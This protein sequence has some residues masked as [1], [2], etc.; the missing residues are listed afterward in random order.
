MFSLETLQSEHRDTR[1]GI[2]CENNEKRKS[3]KKRFQG[4]Q[5]PNCCQLVTT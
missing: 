2:L 5:Q 1:N 3:D 4:H